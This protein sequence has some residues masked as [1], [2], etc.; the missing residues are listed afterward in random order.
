MSE[1]I[2]L[3]DELDSMLFQIRLRAHGTVAAALKCGCNEQ[4]RAYNFCDQKIIG[5]RNHRSRRARVVSPEAVRAEGKEGK[6]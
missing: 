5:I 2:S 6:G 1:L 4:K 3:R